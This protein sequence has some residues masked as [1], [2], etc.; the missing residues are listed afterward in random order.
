[1]APQQMMQCPHGVHVDQCD[2][3]TDRRM[4]YLRRIGGNN[5]GSNTWQT[6]HQNTL[7]DL[8]NAIY[9]EGYM[10]YNQN[11]GRFNNGRTRVLITQNMRRAARNFLQSYGRE[12]AGV[13]QNIAE[14]FYKRLAH[15][16]TTN[17]M[18][19]KKKNEKKKT[20]RGT[21]SK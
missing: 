11:I 8:A 15:E 3:C 19:G 12:S 10:V 4:H 14:R 20:K 6:I 9:P 16:I 13:R 2:I 17:A 21:K 5:R 1:M 18:K 7:Q